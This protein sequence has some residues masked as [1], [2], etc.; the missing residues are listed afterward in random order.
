MVNIIL[1]LVLLLSI[2]AIGELHQDGL[3][4]CLHEQTE[5]ID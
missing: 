2:G 4:R 5:Y 3:F 1:V